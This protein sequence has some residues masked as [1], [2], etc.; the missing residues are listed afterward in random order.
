ME[1]AEVS[2]ASLAASVSRERICEVGTRRTSKPRSRTTES[3]D[4]RMMGALMMVPPER[5]RVSAGEE[6]ASRVKK[7]RLIGFTESE[8]GAGWWGKHSSL[9]GDDECNFLAGRRRVSCE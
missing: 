9:F 1:D 8:R 7:S 2:G 6:R 4:S 5:F 3:G